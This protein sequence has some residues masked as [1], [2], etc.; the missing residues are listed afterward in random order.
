MIPSHPRPQDDA[1]TGRPGKLLRPHD[2][3]LQTLPEGWERLR[4]SSQPQLKRLIA[5][6]PD[7]G[8]DNLFIAPE[9]LCPLVS[10]CPQA[11]FLR[12]GE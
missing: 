12:S 9:A 1:R 5:S 11:S 4:V 10:S 7:T 8:V 3:R 2:L 6:A